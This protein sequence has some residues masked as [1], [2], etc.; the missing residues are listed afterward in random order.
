MKILLCFL[1]MLSMVLCGCQGESKDVLETV[2]DEISVYAE[3][4]FMEV[5]VFVPLDSETLQL[6]STPDNYT[7]NGGDFSVQTRRLLS[8][9][10]ESALR[11]LT[12]SA[13]VIVLQTNRFQ[14]PEYRFAWTEQG[15]ETLCCRGRM[16]Q[17]GD[18]F[19]AVLFRVKESAGKQYDALMAQV[20]SSF[21]LYLDEEV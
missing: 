21:G 1:L 10:A 16:V 2:N 13:P 11:Q 15:E 12:G 20:F 9:S 3:E 19:Y 18:V 14:L 4:P 17:D 8:S 6:S 5:S 7:G